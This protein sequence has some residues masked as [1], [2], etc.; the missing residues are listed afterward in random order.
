MNNPHLLTHTEVAK[1]LGHTPKWLYRNLKRLQR[2]SGFPLAI[3]VV[4]RWD[5]AA[6]DRWI[7]A[8]STPAVSGSAPLDDAAMAALLDQRAAQLAQTRAAG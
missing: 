8:K 2:E 5:G 1:R 3:P 4:R 7:A 6:I